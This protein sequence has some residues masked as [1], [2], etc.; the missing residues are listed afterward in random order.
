M[1]RGAAMELILLLA[2]GAVAVWWMMRGKRFSGDAERPRGSNLS[3]L[4]ERFVVFD[5]E[6]TGLDPNRHE[7]LEIGAIRVNRASDRHDTFQTLVIPQGRIGSRIT[8]LTGITRDMAEAEFR[9]FVGDLPLV[10][11][12]AEFDDAFLKAACRRVEAEGFSNEVCCALLMARRAWPNRKS[13]KLAS[14]AKDGGLSD[15]DTHRALGDC[16]RTL[17]VYAAASSELGTYR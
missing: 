11:F 6:T 14:L 2:L 8:E 13:Y 17:I 4:P 5:L 12:N 3:A 10:A 7:I 16:K 9:E 1:V 15:E